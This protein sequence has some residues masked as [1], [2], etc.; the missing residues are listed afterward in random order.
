MINHV[1]TYLMNVAASSTPAA[2]MIGEEPIDP[3]FVP[4]IVPSEYQK[5]YNKF[6]PANCDRMFKNFRTW[7]L[8]KLMHS[9]WNE[10]WMYEEDSRV[11]YVPFST[12]TWSDNLGTTI[13]PINGS[14]TVYLY[15]RARSKNS[16][17]YKLYD[18]TIQSAG[19]ILVESPTD[20][21]VGY[22]ETQWTTSLSNQL[23]LRNSELLFQ[24][25]QASEG[26][27]FRIECVTSPVHDLSKLYEQL[28]TISSSEWKT[29]VAASNHPTELLQSLNSG[30]YLVNKI[31]AAAFT[32]YYGLQ[33]AV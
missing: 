2:D 25:G 7:Q 18:I 33:N 4:R 6:Y 21:L 20:G 9:S 16:T 27:T 13:Y 15:G 19:S 32:L 12:T 31:A 29:L 5:L 23:E 1:R 3:N 8:L 24:V 11:T 30:A 26:D 22:T 14:P 10:E 28:D 17:L